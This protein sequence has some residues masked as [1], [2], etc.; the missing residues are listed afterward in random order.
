MKRQALVWA[1]IIST[2]LWWLIIIGLLQLRAGAHG[3]GRWVDFG[4]WNGVVKCE[5]LGDADVYNTGGSGAAGLFQFMP[6]TWNWVAE[7]HDRPRLVGKDP[8]T[9]TAAQQLRQ[10]IRLRDMRH[11]GIRHWVCGYRYGDGSG[12]VW[13]HD[14]RIPKRPYRCARN[15]RR[16]WDLP[17]RV[18]NSVCAVPGWSWNP[19][20]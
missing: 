10:A 18:T 6:R 11:G 7:V 8:A 15:L 5:S 16:K 9:R 14:D 12:P 1:V 19:N 17:R 13:V 4:P 2:L 3:E 20:G